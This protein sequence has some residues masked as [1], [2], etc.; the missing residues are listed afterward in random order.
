MAAG[1]CHSGNSSA[2]FLRTMNFNNALNLFQ[3]TLATDYHGH[4]HRGVLAPTEIPHFV[5]V[6]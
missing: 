4:L 1:C 6:G 5:N 3:R 2:S